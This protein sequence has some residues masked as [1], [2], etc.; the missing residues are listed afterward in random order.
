MR[1]SFGSSPRIG[2]ALVVAVLITAAT[3]QPAHADVT[4]FVGL[5]PKQDNRQVWG[6]AGGLSL[7]VVGFE[8][9]MANTPEATLKAQPR[10]RTWSGNVLVQTPF[11]VARVSAYATAGGGGYQEGLLGHTETNVALNTGGGVKIKLAGPLRVRVDYR[12]F[13]LKGTPI[14]ETCHRVYVGGNLAF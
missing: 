8:V 6:F 10:L 2:L 4:A 14:T 1:T 11:D 3:V 5:T 9:E 12:V 13:R 7:L